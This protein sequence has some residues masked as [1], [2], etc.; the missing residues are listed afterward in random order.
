MA[1]GGIYRLVPY[2]GIYRSEKSAFPL[3]VNGIHKIS[4]FCVRQTLPINLFIDLFIVLM[5][6]LQS[7]KILTN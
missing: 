4:H 6:Y 3:L 2:L 5:Y 1:N 7:N